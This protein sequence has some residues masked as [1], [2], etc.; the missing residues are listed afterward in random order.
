MTDE[1]TVPDDFEPISDRELE[2]MARFQQYIIV[3]TPERRRRIDV[4]DLAREILLL[5]A[6]ATPGSAEEATA[7][8]K[9]QAAK[10]GHRQD[11]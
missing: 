8:F 9:R 11:N 7:E 3:A 1:Q 10:M 4:A 5:R 6:A 2:V